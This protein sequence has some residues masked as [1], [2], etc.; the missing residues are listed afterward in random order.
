MSHAYSF[1]FDE[2]NVIT[3]VYEVLEDGT[4]VEDDI[5]ADETYTLID[6]YVVETEDDD[7]EAEWKV[8]ALA[9]DEGIWREVAEGDGPFDTAVLETLG[10]GAVVDDEG[11]DDEDDDIYVFEFDADGMV[12]AKFE[13]E[14]GGALEAEDI[15]D[16]SY[17]VIDGYLVETEGG[18]DP[19]W[20]VYAPLGDSGRWRK[21]ADGDGAFDAAVL[22]TLDDG[23]DDDGFEVEVEDDAYVFEF[24]AETGAV[25]AKFE[26]ED[27]G[28]LEAEDIDDETY[29]LIDG[30]LVETE[31]DEDEFKVYAQDPDTGYWYQVAEGEGEFDAALLDQL[32]GIE[33][34]PVSGDDGVR[35][36][37]DAY[38]FELDDDGNVIAWYEVEDDGS[39]SEE[40]LD[41]TSFSVVNG[42]IVDTASDGPMPQYRVY[43][44]SEDGSV[45]YLMA[46]GYGRFV[47]AHH[48]DLPANVPDHAYEN[49]LEARGITYHWGDE[50][51]NTLEGG[52]GD[53]HIGAGGGNDVASG[54]G[55]NDL[56]G[57]G[58]GNDTMSGGAGNDVIGAGVGDDEADGGEG[59]DIVNGGAGNDALSGSF[60]NDT[61][62]ASYG[63]DR[64]DGG[65][66][67]DDMGGGTGSDLITAGGGR[68]R[69]GGGAGNDTIDGGLGDDFV[70]GGGR[71]DVLMGGSGDDTLNGG[72]GND[73]LTGGD[74]DDVFVFRSL[75]DGEADTITDF[76]DG[77]D[78]LYLRGLDGAGAQ[79]KFDTLSIVDTEAG[80]VIEADGHNITLEGVEAADLG[81]D[82]FILA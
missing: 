64:V 76:E 50:D 23:E 31:T 63:D 33:L 81:L 59:D 29:Q 54:G 4:L 68:D 53:D 28:E 18:D 82:D 62:G 11:E 19:E 49:Y 57:G 45:Y 7:G 70:A 41:D 36:D 1:T 58:T 39:L 37:L 25:T 17:Q 40:D 80:A 74:G 21:V 61:M 2:T 15:D 22:D 20:A 66:G 48:Q 34:P 52:E 35:D 55:G 27:D 8:Y 42:L 46:E 9:D 67:H 78:V 43:V 44:P 71:D 13:V 30:Y 38:R 32:D 12:T 56:M 72:V 60:G 10:D 77:S 3:N 51:D 65:Q 5:D 6:G 14:D 69:V 24:D 73:T 79:A 16:E 26:V 47:P 75:H